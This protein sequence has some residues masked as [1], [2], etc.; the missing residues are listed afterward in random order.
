[1]SHEMIA[2]RCPDKLR[3]KLIAKAEARGQT[4]SN[5]L[6]ALVAKDVGEPIPNKIPPRKNFPRG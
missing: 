2:F 1:M 5:Y 4:L 6:L 3:K